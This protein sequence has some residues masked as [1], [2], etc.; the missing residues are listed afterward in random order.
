MI[1]LPRRLI[2]FRVVKPAH[3]KCLPDI[4][5]RVYH[6]LIHCYIYHIAVHIRE[7]IVHA[8]GIFR[9]NATVL[10]PGILH[11][12]AASFVNGIFSSQE[13]VSAR[14]IY[15]LDQ[16][17]QVIT[18]NAG[19]EFDK[20]RYTKEFQE[21]ANASRYLRGKGMLSR[22][23]SAIS[24]VEY[25]I[26]TPYQQLA[27]TFDRIF[28]MANLFSAAAVVL[29]LFYAY[30]SSRKLSRPFRGLLTALEDPSAAQDVTDETAFITDRVLD[31]LSVNRSM[32]S[33]MEGSSHMVLQAVL[34]KLI[35]GSPTVEVSASSW[36]F[37]L[38]SATVS[39]STSVSSPI[40]ARARHSAA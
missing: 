1:I 32:R 16:D 14:E 34:Y 5:V 29:L 26:F 4:S 36:R 20:L 11:L 30:G 13:F 22:R 19:V 25:V 40:P 28:W 33:A 3:P 37:R 39:L 8:A 27:G 15:V 2:T 6:H 24:G 18:S 23:E 10:L 35:M 12:P 9:I 38:D 17:Q 31:L 7:V 21:A